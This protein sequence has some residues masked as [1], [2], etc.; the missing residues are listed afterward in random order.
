MKIT[1]DFSIKKLKKETLETFLYDES[2]NLSQTAV[3]ACAQM[4][5]FGNTKIF[6]IKT[7]RGLKL[8]NPLNKSASYY[9]DAKDKTTKGSL[10]KFKEVN[11]DTFNL[12]LQF[13]RTKQDSFLFLAERKLA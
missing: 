13:L 3:S 11:E 8:Y 1:D 12:Y 9:L 2:G 6:K 4:T 10:F 7:S 5:K